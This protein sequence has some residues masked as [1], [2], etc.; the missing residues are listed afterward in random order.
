MIGLMLTAGL[1]GF[2]GAICRYWAGIG[3][4]RLWGDK[5]PFGTFAVNAAGCLIMGLV[6]GLWERQTLDSDMHMLLLKTGFCG[7]L[8]TF[9][10]FSN[11][12]LSMIRSGRWLALALYVIPSLALG[13]ACVWL[14]AYLIEHI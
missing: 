2:V 12:A 13:I 3:A 14:G 7:G 4:K 10:T 5:F 8:T 9:S 11:D 6:L 1:G